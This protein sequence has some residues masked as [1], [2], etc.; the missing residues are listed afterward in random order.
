MAAS[1]TRAAVTAWTGSGNPPAPGAAGSVPGGHSP[2]PVRCLAVSLHLQATRPPR[3]RRRECAH[4]I[5]SLPGVE[6]HPAP[7]TRPL[8]QQLTRVVNTRDLGG[9][10]TR[11]GGRVRPRRLLRS[12]TLSR[13]TPEDVAALRDAGVGIVVDLRADWELA[14]VGPVP[15]AFTTHRLVL[16][17]DADR[18]ATHEALRTE[19]LP[20]YYA[21]VIAHARSQLVALVELVAGA[22]AGVLVQCGAGKDRTGISVAL[23]LDLLGVE[24]PAI[25]TDYARTTAAL[26]LIRDDLRR[27]PGYDRAIAE[28]PRDALGAPAEAMTAALAD[29]HDRHGS[30]RDYVLAGGLDP[31]VLDSL[32]DQLVAPAGS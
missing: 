6:T 26:R 14:E 8:G 5:A 22:D 16:V 2:E 28:L 19:G 3:S 18:D 29:L 1:A 25:A 21:W 17:P 20:G 30:S 7:D 31:A 23:L 15:D 32:R 27:T 13:A 10:P 24:G 4:Q 11:D 12:A 9:T